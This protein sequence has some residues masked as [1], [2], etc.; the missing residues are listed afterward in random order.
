MNYKD[1]LSK[2]FPV[3]LNEAF[4]Y[5]QS[6][7]LTEGGILGAKKYAMD[8]GYVSNYGTHI[9]FFRTP[10]EFVTF[11]VS[12]FILILLLTRINSFLTSKFIKMN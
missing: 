9:W 12:I 6:I 4:A 10:E 5:A 3:N 11:L 1:Q 2:N 7:K 8:F